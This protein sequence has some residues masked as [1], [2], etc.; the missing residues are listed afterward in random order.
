MGVYLLPLC[1]YNH[2]GVPTQFPAD[3][4]QLRHSSIGTH[5]GVVG[6][7][8]GFLVGLWVGLLVGI[9]V[10]PLVGLG[11]GRLVGLEVGFCKTWSRAWWT[12]VCLISFPKLCVIPNSRHNNVSTVFNWVTSCSITA[13]YFIAPTVFHAEGISVLGDTKTINKGV[14]FQVAGT[15]FYHLVGTS[16][17]ELPRSF[18]RIT[19]SS[20]CTTKLKSNN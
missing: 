10:G 3:N 9:R 1:R 17:L 20:D 16:I 19:I 4:H 13:A 18:T 2:S 12:K 15:T 11:V 8:V 7:G 14:I 5:W 6:L